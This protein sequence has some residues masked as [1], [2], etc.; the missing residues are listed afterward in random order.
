MQVSADDDVTAA[1]TVH[2]QVE[3]IYE[4]HTIKVDKGI[5]PLLD[6]L[7]AHGWRTGSSCE[8]W[9]AISPVSAGTAGI[10]F[11]H[12]KPAADF[13]RLC[14]TVYPDHRGQ[15]QMFQVAAEDAENRPGEQH[16]VGAWMVHF[17]AA[18]VERLVERL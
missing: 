13:R 16:L 11:M 6:K 12:R 9:S 7:W 15:V 2:E 3:R 5:A 8:D 18:L 1:A 10:A 4:G 17:P 14:I